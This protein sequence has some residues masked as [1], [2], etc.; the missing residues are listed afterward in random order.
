[1]T[2]I[3]QKVA[4]DAKALPKLADARQLQD[5]LGVKR[6]TAERI[7]RACPVK[8]PVGRKVF[9]YRDD[10]LEVLKANEIRDAA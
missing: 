8:I 2:G 10:V 5:E 7:M 9:V 1:M 3:L 6:A 4:V